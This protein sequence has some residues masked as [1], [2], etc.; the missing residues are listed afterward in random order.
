MTSPSNPSDQATIGDVFRVVNEMRKEI[1]T[2]RTESGTLRTD[3]HEFRTSVEGQLDDIRQRLEGQTESALN[4]A[5]HVLGEQRGK[6]R[7]LVDWANSQGA[8]IHPL[9]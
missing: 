7:E 1:G 2:L 9:P 5:L 6:L 8:R 4:V 3:L